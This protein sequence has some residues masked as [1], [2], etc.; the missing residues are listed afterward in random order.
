MTLILFVLVM[1]TPPVLPLC[2]ISTCSD[3]WSNT[4]DHWTTAATSSFPAVCCVLLLVSF[5]PMW[6]EHWSVFLISQNT[7]SPGVSCGYSGLQMLTYLYPPPPS[8]WSVLRWLGSSSAD[9]SPSTSCSSRGTQ[10]ADCPCGASPTTR[11]CSRCPPPQ[12]GISSLEIKLSVHTGTLQNDF[13]QKRFS[14]CEKNHADKN[15]LDA[16]SI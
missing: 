14:L 12:V 7:A 15:K 2:F 8:S 4:L 5:W 1:L 11:L 10:R 16:I 6:H 9:G 3:G 13:F